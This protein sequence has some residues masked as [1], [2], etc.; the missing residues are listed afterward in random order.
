[1]MRPITYLLPNPS[2][3]RFLIC[4]KCFPYVRIIWDMD[5]SWFDSS[6]IRL[7]LGTVVCGSMFF[8]NSFLYLFRTWE[9]GVSCFNICRLT[10]YCHKIITNKLFRS[11]VAWISTENVWSTFICCGGNYSP[12][13][14]YWNFDTIRFS[15]HSIAI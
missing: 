5:S 11:Y 4:I 12:M 8:V 1:M 13:E 15:T 9:T 14:W 2:V 6:L 3:Y 10:I 7:K